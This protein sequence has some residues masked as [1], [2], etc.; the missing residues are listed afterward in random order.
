MGASVIAFV[1]GYSGTLASTFVGNLPLG[2]ACF[3]LLASGVISAGS[4]TLVTAR[5][6]GLSLFANAPIN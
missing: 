1:S 3:S 6:M 4:I 5:R 2:F